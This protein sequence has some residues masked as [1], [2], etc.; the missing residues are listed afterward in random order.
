MDS[1]NIIQDKALVELI[2]ISFFS[3]TATAKNKKIIYNH[4]N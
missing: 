2:R 1:T 3:D 4:E